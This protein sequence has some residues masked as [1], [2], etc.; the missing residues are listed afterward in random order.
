MSNSRTQR[1]YIRLLSSSWTFNLILQ[2]TLLLS[3][4]NATHFRGGTAW[5]Q[6]S[7]DFSEDLKQIHFEFKLNWRTS[8]YQVPICDSANTLSSGFGTWKT[9]H[10]DETFS[11]EFYCVDYY[12]SEDW[13]IG[14]NHVTFN[15]TNNDPFVMWYDGRCWI[16]GLYY[17][18]CA[19]NI[20]VYIDVGIRSDTTLPNSS[21]RSVTTP[22]IRMQVGCPETV[23]IPT[24][25][26]DSDDKM[27]CRFGETVQE[28]GEVCQKYP[29]FSI[30][31]ETCQL[32]YNGGGRDT[33]VTVALVIEDHPS[34]TITVDRGNGNVVTKTPSDTLSYV[35]LQY[36][37]ALKTS[38]YP[39]NAKPSFIDDTPPDGQVTTTITGDSFNISLSA[40]PSYDTGNITEVIIVSMAGVSKSSLTETDD[41]VYKVD[42]SWKPTTDQIG[43]NI[44]CF[45]A[46][47]DIPRTSALRCITI[48]VGG[49]TSP[50]NVNNGGC[51]DTCQVSGHSYHCIC[52]K[53]CWTLASNGRTCKP[54]LQIECNSNVMDITVSA[55]SVDNNALSLGTSAPG[56]QP[57]PEE[58]R[59]KSAEDSHKFSFGLSD[60]SMRVEEDFWTIVY[61]NTVRLF[62]DDS[63]DDETQNSNS[64]ITRGAWF[65]VPVSCTFQKHGNLT[66]SFQP[67]EREVDL[68]SVPGMGSFSFFLDFYNSSDFS[69]AIGPYDY[70]LQFTVNSDIYFGLR[71][72]GGGTD[73]QLFTVNCIAYPT[74]NI[75]DNTNS[76]TMIGNGCIL[77]STLV[78][79]PAAS[80]MENHFSIKAFQFREISNNTGPIVVHIQCS[81][82]VCVL[83]NPITRCSQGCVA[84]DQATRRRREIIRSSFVVNHR[85][86]RQLIEDDDDSIPNNNDPN[87]TQSPV[88]QVNSSGNIQII[89]ELNVKPTPSVNPP[90]DGG[91]PPGDSSTS[92]V[93]IVSAAVGGCTFLLLLAI[94]ACIVYHNKVVRHRNDVVPLDHPHHGPAYVRD[95]YLPNLDL[96]PRGANNDLNADA[97]DG[98]IWARRVI[99]GPPSHIMQLSQHKNPW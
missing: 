43:T 90:I 80:N 18:L 71:A 75:N 83:N 97:Q 9:S 68:L 12:A 23:K 26:P 42:L 33:L 31:E 6:P 64:P 63:S 60:C 99:S 77:D 13:M 58:C 87:V 40:K 91:N 74:A 82:I 28:C 10:N 67:V 8:F 72:V 84:G 88:Q 2:T 66:T 35:S 24:A 36:I 79:Y 44:L 78:E 96:G 47:D 32:T 89:I 4:A 56:T 3:I 65:Y 16:D 5:W 41:N 81:V 46:V 1:D 34:T 76:Y 49:A 93:V 95:I 48:I 15:I 57:I 98:Y 54:D 85:Y 30:H 59:V 70:P 52:P 7:P 37:V 61:S 17:S 73:M 11:A 21:P 39:C 20:S 69:V 86:K 25:D 45:S 94:I 51:S 14:S 92:F 27:T 19:W 55:C 53:D 29:Y 62:A 50:C 22:I 38:N